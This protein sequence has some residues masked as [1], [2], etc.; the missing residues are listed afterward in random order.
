MK[1][2]WEK[3][4]TNEKITWHTW[5]KR[6]W[7]KIWKKKNFLVFSFSYTNDRQKGRIK[8]REIKLSNRT[9]N[10]S[11]TRSRSNYSS[12]YYYCYHGWWLRSFPVV[13]AASQQTLC[14]GGREEERTVRVTTPPGRARRPAALK[15]LMSAALQAQVARRSRWKRETRL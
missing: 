8:A 7:R 3:E 1:Y 5:A 15:Y 14:V 2:N 6:L 9:A 12:C 10:A 13:T 4:C 11:K